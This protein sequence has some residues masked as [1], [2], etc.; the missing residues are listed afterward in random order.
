MITMRLGDLVVVFNA[1]PQQQK[2]H[3]ASLAGTAYRLH[4]VQASG[5]DPVVRTASY[6]GGTFTVPARTVAV[7]TRR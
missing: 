2:Q 3:I 7:F 5:A 1:T 6:S 4:P